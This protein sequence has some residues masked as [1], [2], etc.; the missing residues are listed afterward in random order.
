MIA[1]LKCPPEMWPR[2][3]TMIPIARRS[4]AS[5]TATMS[6]PLM[7]PGAAAEEDQL[8]R[9]DELRDRHTQRIPVDPPRRLGGGSDGTSRLAQAPESAR[10]DSGTRRHLKSA[11]FAAGRNS[12][13]LADGVA[14]RLCLRKVLELLERVVLDLADPLARDPEGRPRPLRASAAGRRSGRNAA[15]SRGARGAAEC[16]ARS[17][18]SRRAT[19]TRCRTGIGPARP[20]RSRQA[21]L[22]LFADRLLEQPDAAPCAGSPVPRR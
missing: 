13:P 14:E 6:C 11:A 2:F 16:R 8:E 22:L 19:A 5:A 12:K 21:G 20:G 7:I 1:G 4:S 3:V 17:M 9:F 18:S 15:R 10:A